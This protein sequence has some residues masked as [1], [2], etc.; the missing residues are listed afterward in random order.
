MVV[1]LNHDGIK[2]TYDVIGKDHYYDEVVDVSSE[3]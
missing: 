2:L 1:M 3:K